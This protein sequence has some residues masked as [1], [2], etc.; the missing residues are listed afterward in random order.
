MCKIFVWDATSLEGY[1]LVEIY[2]GDAPEVGELYSHNGED[3]E[4]VS[5]EFFLQDEADVMVVPLKY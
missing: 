4:V 2:R 1:R 5:V 3:Y